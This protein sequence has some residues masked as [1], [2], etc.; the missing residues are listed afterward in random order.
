M[1]NRMQKLICLLQPISKMLPSSFG[2]GGPIYG[3]A[4]PRNSPAI[5]ASALLASG[6]TAR[7][8]TRSVFLRCAL[9]AACA[10]AA[11]ACDSGEKRAASPS[12][13]AA[14]GEALKKQPAVGKAPAEKAAVATDQSGATSGDLPR[15][16]LVAYAQFE[17]G[18]DGKATAKP[19][20][21]R[22][23]MLS[24]K[25]GRWKVEVIEDPES[26]VMHKAM[27]YS[28]KSGKPGILAFAGSAAT[29]KLWRR[30]A[31]GFRSETLWKEDFG[32]KFSRMRDAEVA[33]VYGDG[34]PAVV[35]GTHDQGLV[36]VVR[37]DGK[38]GYG[39]VKLGSKPDT[40]IHEIE[41]GD[42]DGDKTLEVYATPS[43]PNRMDKAEQEGSVIRYIPKEKKGPVVVADLGNRHAKEILVGDL[44]GDGRDELYAAVEALTSRKGGSVQIVEPVEIRR[45]DA[46]TPPDAGQVVATL[47]DR[48]CRF[49]TAGDVDGDGRREM[50]AAAFRSG[51]WLLRPPVPGG[52]QAGGAE[53]KWTV[54][55]IDRNSSGF[56]HA[57]LLTDL[58]GDG[59][60]ELYVAA[61]DQGELHRYVWKKGAF[62]RETLS[63]RAVPAAM[64]TWNLMPF[65]VADL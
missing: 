15:G 24:R 59:R 3:V 58:D 51:V 7:R 19:G 50:V 60:D 16:L 41:I 42:L 40:F 38:G 65:N 64:M 5:A 20:P 48:F 21:A 22:L 28:P 12:A 9:A 1:R 44:D 45:Y 35:V 23:E 8:N 33:D 11:P 18:R 63:G 17:I 14:Q 34:L 37:P 2:R 27:V 10:A 61:D 30:T 49:L 53:G 57:A 46:A 56:E 25:G 52:K 54:T 13:P 47:D 26:N 62:Q 29:V 6:T 55:S 39:V 36:A 43:E 32:G 4:P 31:Q